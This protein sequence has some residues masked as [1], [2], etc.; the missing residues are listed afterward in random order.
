[1]RARLDDKHLSLAWRRA[2]SDQGL[3][4]AGSDRA[5]HVAQLDPGLVIEGGAEGGEDLLGTALD[6][7]HVLVIPGG[8]TLKWKW[9]SRLYVHVHLVR[10]GVGVRFMHD[11]AFE[12]L[13]PQL[14]SQLLQHFKQ[15]PETREEPSGAHLH[16]GA[17]RCLNRM[18]PTSDPVPG[19]EQGVNI[20]Q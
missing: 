6:P 5:H 2:H 1:M 4:S 10:R 18:D 3:V 13:L 17:I 11:V 9:S 12:I 15:V 14:H 19:L 16:G 7:K 20:D 8:V